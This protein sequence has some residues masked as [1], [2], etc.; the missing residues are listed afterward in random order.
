M[1]QA[2]HPTTRAALWMSGALLSFLAMAVGAREAA[3]ELNTFQILFFRS[4][5]GLIVLSVLLQQRGWH[6]ITTGR[7]SLHLVRNISH[8][9]GQYGWFYGIAFIPLAEVF[10]IEF[11]TPVWT[12]LIAALL[13]G[14]RLTRSRVAAI[15]LGLAGV[16]LI[17]RPGTGLM[18]PA[19]LA[20]LLGAIS[21]GLAHTLTRKLTRTDAPLAILFY[22][23]AIQLPFGL[24]PTLFTWTT[25]SPAVW[26]WVLVV[27]LTA[28]SAHYCMTRA[29]TIADTAVVVPMDFLRL[30][31]VAAVGATLYGEHLE[32][33]LIAGA[34]LI[35]TGNL[36]SLR[37]ER[38]RAPIVNAK[39]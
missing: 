20:V 33:S 32:W 13:L 31:L 16:L 37:A 15:C 36:L 1:I 30:P 19:A 10:A 24:V 8:F 35:L 23:A 17:V 21:F 3:A 14:E 4:L 2:A 12:A 9:A 11:T 27:G 26:P 28:L 5:I 22:M 34:A 25:P 39:S 6:R 7:F 29:L 38:R 18:H